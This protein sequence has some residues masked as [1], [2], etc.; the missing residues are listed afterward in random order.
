MNSFFLNLKQKFHNISIVVYL[1]V[2][3]SFSM[4]LVA[5]QTMSLGS[6]QFVLPNADATMASR[7]IRMKIANKNLNSLYYNLVG[8]IAFTQQAIPDFTVRQLDVYYSKS[9]NMAHMEINGQDIIIPLEL[10]ELR[11]IVNF[12]NSDYDVVMTMYGKQYGIMNDS[13]SQ[14]ILFHPAFVDDIMGLRLLQVDAM[15]ILSG[16]NGCFPAYSKDTL[17]MTISERKKYVRLNA[18]FEKEGSNYL[19]KAKDAYHYI[20]TIISRKYESYIYTDIN[21]PIHFNITNKSITFNGM[22]YYQFSKSTTNEMDPMMYYYQVKYLLKNYD[23]YMKPFFDLLDISGLHKDTINAYKEAIKVGLNS[24]SDIVNQSD[25]TD[26]QKA[27]ELMKLIY[28]GYDDL[29]DAELAQLCMGIISAACPFYVSADD[30]TAELKSQS[31]IVRQLNPIVYQEVDDV[32][33]WT[34]LFRYIKTKNPSVWHQFV[35]QV[36]SS[37]QKVPKL[38][39]PISVNYY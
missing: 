16:Q 25:K 36:N 31:E 13:E 6:L 18:Q 19:S 30:I 28:E 37:K 7:S 17:C 4:T 32:C 24:F 8:G 27:D 22:P 3:I 26:E 35:T 23:T 39:T 33:H 20:N 9:D 11:P 5:Q 12:A 10:F 34:A 15:S 38:L 14:E 29:E 21:Q 1:I 2:S